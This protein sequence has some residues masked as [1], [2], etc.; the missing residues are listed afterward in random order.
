M[1]P[2][3]E[4]QFIN[5]YLTNNDL[6]ISDILNVID[7]NIL[8]HPKNYNAKL[9]SFIDIFISDIDHVKIILDKMLPYIHNGGVIRFRHWMDNLK[10][11]NSL[12]DMITLYQIEHEAYEWI[13]FPSTLFNNKLFIIRKRD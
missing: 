5:Q 11:K 10:D 12:F 2:D 7:I 1:L 6:T 13:D 3:N 4:I 9:Y 8:L